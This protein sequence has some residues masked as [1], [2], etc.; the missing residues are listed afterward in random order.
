VSPEIRNPPIALAGLEIRLVARQHVAPLGGPGV[1]G[2]YDDA[3]QRFDHRGGLKLLV[4]EPELRR[5]R[6]DDRDQADHEPQQAEQQEHI[7]DRKARRHQNSVN[8]LIR[9][10]SREVSWFC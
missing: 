8:R 10:E 9:M 4:A 6:Q 5:R 7:L 2:E 3:V 1:E